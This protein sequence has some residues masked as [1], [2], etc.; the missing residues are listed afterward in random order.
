MEIKINSLLNDKENIIKLYEIMYSNTNPCLYLICEYCDMGTIMNKHKES[1]EYYHNFKLVSYL[2]QETKLEYEI[3]CESS[4]NSINPRL[5]K[6]NTLNYLRKKKLSK[7]IFP[8]IFKGLLNIHKSGIIHRDLKPENVVFSSQ[9]NLCKII[10]FSHSLMIDHNPFYFNEPAGS[11]HFQAPELF[12]NTSNNYDP[13]KSDIW[14]MGVFMFLFL[15]ERFP[16]DSDSEIE[17]QISIAK[18]NLDFPEDFKDIDAISLL[19]KLLD[20][21]PFNRLTDINLIFEDKFFN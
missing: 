8:Q 16:F 6:K 3:E 4:V 10:D 5:I 12:W 1:F 18:K 7:I 9:D 20:K 19:T 14:S 17:L 11:I 15:F 2:L 21:D 13:F